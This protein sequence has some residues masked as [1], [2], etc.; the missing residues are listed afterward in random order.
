MCTHIGLGIETATCQVRP[1]VA[2]GIDV[3]LASSSGGLHL[4]RK[5][6]MTCS[7]FCIFVPR[8]VRGIPSTGA[9]QVSD[10][11]GGGAPKSHRS[12]NA[13]SAMAV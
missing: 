3:G 6:S 10:R 13:T 2:L 8:A 7:T 9:G 12:D 5:A 4:S 11:G 1:G